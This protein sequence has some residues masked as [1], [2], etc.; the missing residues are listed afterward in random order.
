MLGQREAGWV[1]P[2]VEDVKEMRRN[3]QLAVLSVMAHPSLRLAEKVLKTIRGCLD[4]DRAR[5]YCEAVLR[6]LRPGDRSALEAKMMRGY[7]YKTAYAKKYLAEGVEKGREKGRKEGREAGREEGRKDALQQM[8]LTLARQKLD[9]VTR[10]DLAVLRAV[11][12][13]EKLSGLVL[14]LSES[15]EPAQARAALAKIERAARKGERR[16]ANAA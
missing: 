4:E 2:I 1:H 10:A 7:K 15:K 12:D 5:L 13:P 14:Q 6:A 11:D 9:R 8:A 16:L 3:P